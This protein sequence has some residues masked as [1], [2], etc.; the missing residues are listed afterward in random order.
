MKYVNLVTLFTLLSLMMAGAQP[1]IPRDEVVVL[2]NSEMPGS[3]KLAE[4]YAAKRKI[5]AENLVGL[6]MPKKG[7]IKRVEYDKFIGAPLKKVFGEK[8]WWK[9]KEASNGVRHAFENKVKVIVS[10]YGVPYGV[11]NVKGMAQSEGVKLNAF[12]KYNCASVDSELAALSMSGVAIYNRVA[13]RYFRRDISFNKADLPYMMLV[14]RID[15]DSPETCKR[16]I[17]DALEVEET[18]LWGMAYLDKS[19]K[20]GSYKRG[21]EWIAEI[22]K[23]NWMYGIP[24]TMDENKD[25]YL[26]NYPMRDVAMYFGWYTSKVNGPFL[27]PDF[28]FKKGAVAVHL[29]SYSASNL[30]N[31]RVRWVGPL[32]SKGA[33]A[34]VGNV[35][36]PYLTGSHYFNIL[37][38]RLTQGYS[39]VESAYMAIPFLS[40]Q[41]VVLGD[42]LYQPYLHL[43]GSGKVKKEDK[44]YRACAMAYKAWGDDIALLV[45]KLRSAAHKVNDGRYL[46]VVGLF[47][48]FQGELKESE[49]FHRSAKKMYMLRSDKTRNEIHLIE[50]MKEAGDKVGAINACKAL[51]YRVKG[52]PEAMTV[53]SMLNIL[54]PPPPPPAQPNKKIPLK[55]K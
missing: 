39:L 7:K 12:N 54:S 19:K 28:K 41:N 1:I 5:P 31:P 9:L 50:M 33:A 32:L 29:H 16:M 8:G 23:T 4:Y 37:H 47:R 44:F 43:S 21:D 34:T 51:L 17:D 3:K 25:T 20:P 26:T 55:K 48:R 6:P 10:M 36:E 38:D 49:M 2:Y 52:D 27:N 11:D 53:K 42:P 15:A 13:N 30:R 24:T 35:Y 22:E 45:K 14:G 40:W 18:G 46:E